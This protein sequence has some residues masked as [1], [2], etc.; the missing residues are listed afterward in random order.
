MNKKIVIILFALFL[1]TGFIGNQWSVVGAV[2]TIPYIPPN[3]KPQ[4]PIIPVTGGTTKLINCQDPSIQIPEVG[5]AV[6]TPCPNPG[7]NAIM[8]VLSAE[9]IKLLKPF[10]FLTEVFQVI[11]E[12]AYQG[13]IIVGVYLAKAEKEA[14]LKDPELGLYKFDT[15]KNE[16][17]RIIAVL[18]GDY[19]SAETDLPGVFVVGKP[20]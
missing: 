9:D 16:W 17:V 13:K 15:I 4:D 14:L 12:S 11:T 18:D 5:R 8:V 6:F 20:N 10:T 19:L 7:I 2:G 3:V 1:V